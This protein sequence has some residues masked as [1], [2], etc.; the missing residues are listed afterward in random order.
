MSPIANENHINL[1]N[2]FEKDKKPPKKHEETSIN[3]PN[4]AKTVKIAK[5]WHKRVYFPSA[6]RRGWH[7]HLACCSPT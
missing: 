6:S 3:S 2:N 5:I 1:S 7:L 4:G